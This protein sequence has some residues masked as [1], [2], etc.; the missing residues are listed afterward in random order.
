MALKIRLRRMGRRKAPTYRIV[1]AESSMPRDGR[2]VA[3]IGHYNPRTEPMTIQVDREK[4]LYWLEQGA[5]PTDT[6][7]SLLKRAGVFGPAPAVTEEPAGAVQAAARQAA[8]AVASAAEAVQEAAADAVEA[9]RERLGGEEES[10]AAE[11]ADTDAAAA[12]GDAAA[13][14]EEKAAPQGE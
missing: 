2:F 13:A 1:V 7:R 9:V 8:S 11:A 3:S 14:D 5:V 6:T 4:A 10:P 12:E